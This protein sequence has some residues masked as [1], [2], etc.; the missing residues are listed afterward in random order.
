MDVFWTLPPVSRTIIAAAFV[1]SL[2][3]HGGLISPLK[4]L[5][6]IPWIFKIFPEVWR[7]ITPFLLT[8]G[9]LDFV[10]DLYFLYKY[11]SELERDSP[12]FT[13]PG[14]FFTYVI[15][16]GSVITLS[17]G[18]LLQSMVF[19]PALIIAFMYTYGQVNTGRKASFIVIQ[20]PVELLP[21][22]NIVLIMLMRGWGQAQTA[23][24]GVVAAHLYEFLTR[25]YPT[26]GRGRNFISTPVIV[27]RWFGAH[28]STQ[29]Y[30]SYGTSY[31]PAD[32][33]ARQAGPGSASA[34]GSSWFSGNSWSG[35]GAGR[36]LG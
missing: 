9:G 2:L 12:R 8:G 25:I 24:C 6:H 18:V 10:F 33:A 4:V 3:V 1:E 23:A 5:F 21:W 30:R 15:F 32:R 17:A 35:R 31:Q 16:V 19:T 27:K 26:Y 36:R 7:L 20:I 29:T 13:V 22:A 11:G 34:S 14:D 28:R